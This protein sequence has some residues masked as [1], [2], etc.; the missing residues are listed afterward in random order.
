MIE[1]HFCKAKLRK[2]AHVPSRAQGK[3]VILHVFFIPQNH[4]KLTIWQPQA[5]QETRKRS[6]H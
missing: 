4:P 2:N 1:F 6:D 3:F 5:A